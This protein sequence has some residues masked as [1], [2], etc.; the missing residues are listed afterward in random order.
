MEWWETLQGA[1]IG[2][3][4]INH[5]RLNFLLMKTNQLYL[6]NIIQN[7]KSMALFYPIP[8]FIQELEKEPKIAESNEIKEWDDGD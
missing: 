2:L 1:I 5:I 8:E 6:Y 3:L 7:S 4:L